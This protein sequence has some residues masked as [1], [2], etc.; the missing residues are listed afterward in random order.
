MKFLLWKMPSSHRNTA[1]SWI[2]LIFQHRTKHCLFMHYHIVLLVSV[3][4]VEVLRKPIK[5]PNFPN[6]MFCNRKMMLCQTSWVQLNS[7][8]RRS[9]GQSAALF[10]PLSCFTHSM[11]SLLSLSWLS[12]ISFFFPSFLMW[13]SRRNPLFFFLYFNLEIYL[14]FFYFLLILSG[15]K[16]FS[17][18]A[19]WF[20]K[21]NAVQMHRWKT[22]FRPNHA[23]VVMHAS[24]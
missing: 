17:G 16:A 6:L 5:F 20:F 13:R 18:M 1:N 14:V 21:E 9:A 12:F 4:R 7:Q 8:T 24:S 3:Q 10:L 15:W 11:F 22:T 19:K 2:V 23:P